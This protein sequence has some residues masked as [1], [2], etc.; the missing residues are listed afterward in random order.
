MEKKMDKVIGYI[1]T[2]TTKQNISIKK[3]RQ[4]IKDYCR[5][6]HLELIEIISEEGIS[7]NKVNRDG[8]GRMMEMVEAGNV[9]GVIT[10]W[11]SRAGRRAHET[12]R[13]ITESLE[14][15]VALISLKEGIDTRT[16]GGR[17]QAKMMAVWA[18]EELIQIQERIR[19]AIR[20]KKSNGLVYNGSPAYGTYVKNGLIYADDFEMKIVRNIKNQRTRG[21][22][23]YKIMKRLNELEI[24]TK[25][26]KGRGW[27]INQIK[28]VY[29]FHYEGSTPV[30]IK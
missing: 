21:W 16:P 1:R 3:Q 19:D 30:V 17:M 24:P 7:G 10:M 20:Y 11:V 26:R 12:I 28:Q 2:S 22:T 14:K 4:D 13:F 9:D 27:T 15:G 29:S 23:W 5:K 8:F 18:E 25:M 6:E